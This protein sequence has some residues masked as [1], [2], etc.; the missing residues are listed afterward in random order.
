[1]KLLDPQRLRE[2]SKLRTWRSFGWLALDYACLLLA[3]G[4]AIGFHLLCVRHGAHWAW[5]VP[6]WLLAVFLMG[7]LQ[8][9][10]G[11]MG[12]EASHYLL[13]P[14]RA[15]NDR[16]A[17][18]L[19][20]H[21]LF[22]DIRLYR[23]KHAGHHLHPNHPELDPNLQ[24][25][26][27]AQVYAKFPMEKGRFVRCF[28]LLFFWP[29]FVLGIL[30]YLFQTLAV[31]TLE[32]PAVA[33]KDRMALLGRLWFIV[34]AV[35]LLGSAC[36]GRQSWPVIVGLAAV[37]LVVWACAPVQSFSDDGGTPARALK[38]SALQRLGFNA[39]LLMVGALS[40][41]FGNQVIVGYLLL[42]ICPLVYVYPY[43]MQLREIYQHANGGMGDLDNSRIMHVG[44]FTRWALLGYGNDFHLI[45]HLY[46][47]I[48]NDRLAEVHEALLRES[49]DYAAAVPE[50]YGVVT[51]P[52]GRRSLLD[53]LAQKG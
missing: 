35:V 39:L 29:P 26:R 24:V 42:W 32:G 53:L 11:L 23:R 3:M 33:R 44:A 15:W 31:G 49:G 28:F 21:P 14:D 41:R 4:G 17:N 1:M 50:S 34:S 25:G 10:L 19:I 7:I 46:P 2:W 47:N 30:R 6:V 51:A 38:G 12:H 18:L 5:E 20:F 37:A 8:H 9:R 16:L 45:H 52:A 13:L 40:Q 22:S 48:P 27:L 43:L 36:A